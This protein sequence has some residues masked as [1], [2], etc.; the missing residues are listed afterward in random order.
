MFELTIDGVPYAR[1]ATAELAEA[2]RA[3]LKRWASTST[4]F[5]IVPVESPPLPCEGCRG[6]GVATRLIWRQGWVWG[7]GECRGCAGSGT[8][9]TGATP[10]FPAAA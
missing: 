4:R 6:T 2:G 8:A 5:E 10:V 1:Y 9:G 3:T 7:E